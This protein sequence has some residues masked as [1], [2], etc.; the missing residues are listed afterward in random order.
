M[1]PRTVFSREAVVAAGYEV[2]RE[3]GLKRLTARGVAKRLQASV[4]PVY[5]WFPSMAALQSEVV[6]TVKDVLLEYTAR[7]YTD[8]RFLN[9]GVGIARF[10]REEPALFRA[11]FL[12]RNDFKGVIDEILASLCERMREDPPFTDMPEAERM[13]LLTKMWVYTHG[14]AALICVGVL[15]DTSD[16]FIISSLRSVGSVVS[17]AAIAEFERGR[18]GAEAGK[19]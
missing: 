8:I 19:A 1:P 2:L 12:E 11:M 17:R 3:G 16:A 5:Q 4:A 9:M 14:L 18:Q 13:A 15:E 6:G 7:P 10:A